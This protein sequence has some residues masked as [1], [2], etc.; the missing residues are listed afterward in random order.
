MDLLKEKLLEKCAGSKW[1]SIKK[2]TTPFITGLAMASA[3]AVI[4]GGIAVNQQWI[5][6]QQKDPAF[7]KMLEIHP[8]LQEED[9]ADV[10]KYFD[11]LYHF[12]PSMAK[13]P[14]AAGA[15]IRQTLRMATHGGPTIDTIKTVTDIESGTGASKPNALQSLYMDQLNTAMKVPMDSGS[16]APASPAVSIVDKTELQTAFNNAFE[17]HMFSGNP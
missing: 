2:I 1:E 16:S 7:K 17:N 14:L 6:K 10:M 11:S 12:A 4:G 13:D 9:K 5:N 3:M 15:Y 8:E